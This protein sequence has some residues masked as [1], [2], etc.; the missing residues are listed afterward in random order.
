M[1]QKTPSLKRPP[2]IGTWKNIDD[3]SNNYEPKKVA[4]H[5][6]RRKRPPIRKNPIETSQNP[7]STRNGH[8]RIENQ[9]EAKRLL[10]QHPNST[11]PQTL[12]KRS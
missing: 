8:Q 9:G 4:I 10:S 1:K 3:S 12:I 2:K 5:K 11:H 7:N 6:I